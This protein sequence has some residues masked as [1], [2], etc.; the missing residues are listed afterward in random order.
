MNNGIISN[1]SLPQ[2]EKCYANYLLLWRYFVLGGGG[3]GK[4]AYI[5]T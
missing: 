4:K 1:F 2:L 3:L 5:V